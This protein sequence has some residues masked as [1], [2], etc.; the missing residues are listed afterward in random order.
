VAWQVA[1]TATVDEV[2]RL[3]LQTVRGN[4][5]L[6]SRL[7]LQDHAGAYELRLHEGDGEADEDFPALD[8]CATHTHARVAHLDYGR[9][10]RTEYVV[11]VHVQQS[12]CPREGRRA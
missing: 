5:A 3:V 7:R 2:I 8:R 9:N 4:A 1:D 11:R 12:P 10:R 6:A